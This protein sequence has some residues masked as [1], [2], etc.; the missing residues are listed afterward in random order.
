MDVHTQFKEVVKSR[1]LIKVKIS[2]NDFCQRY[3]DTDKNAIIRYDP[4]DDK[5]PVQQEL[6]QLI[7]KKVVDKYFYLLK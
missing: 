7:I 3:I 1:G 6:D 4:Y 5:Q 2:T